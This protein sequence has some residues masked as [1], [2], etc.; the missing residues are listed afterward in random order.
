MKE[1]LDKYFFGELSQRGKEVFF[2][3]IESEEKLKAEFIRMQNIVTLSKLFTQKGDQVWAKQMKNE[4]EDRINRKQIRHVLWNISKYAAVITLIL[5]NGWLLVDRA[6]VTKEEITYTTI[7]VPK[8]QRVS[9]TLEDGTEAWL[10]PRTILRIPNKF[11]KDQRLIQL[12][13]EGFLS[14]TKDKKR[15]FIV[16]TGNFDVKV[17]GTRFNVFAYSESHRFETDLIDGKVEIFNRSKPEDTIV[18]DPGEKASLEN[19]Q[20]VKSISC[21]CNEEYLKNGIFN[22]NNKPFGEILEYLSLWYNVQFDIKDSAKKEWLVSGKFRQS[23]EVKNI[24]KGLQGVHT[25]KYK[26]NNER[27]IEIY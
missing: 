5:I 20:L 8:G 23:D 1:D 10:S 14:V 17:L 19:N 21:F 7:E 9:I 6:H 18:L 24:L 13:G 26:E 15:P 4:L 3:K 2:D 22:F 11:S 25:F 16:Q 12:D 27:N